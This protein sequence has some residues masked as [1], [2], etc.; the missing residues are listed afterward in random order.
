MLVFGGL[1]AASLPLFV[2]VLAVLGT[3]LSLYVMG[4]LMDVSVYAI[5]LTTA[6]GLGLAIDYSLF[7]VS[8]YREEL[9]NGRT[10][11]QAGVRTVET[12]GRT[13]AF[14]G[15]TVAVSLSALLVFPQYFLRSF[16]YAGI[17]VVSWQCWRRRRRCRR[18]SP[19]S[20]T[21]STPCASSV[22]ASQARRRMASGTGSR[23]GDASADPVALGVVAILLL[24]ARLP[25]GAVRHA[26]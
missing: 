25:A 16:A 10:V 1:L 20:V 6:L 7:I 13:I 3:F 24:L 26:R 22:V 21:A 23:R 9:R 12:A 2:G 17:A 19:S 8:R 5:N 4:S 15:L 14:S 18:C 11:E